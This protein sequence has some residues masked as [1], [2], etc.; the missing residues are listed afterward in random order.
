MSEPILQEP[1]VR[2]KPKKRTQGK[3]RQLPPFHVILENDD[4]HTMGFVV[5]VLQ[6][7]L[8][9]EFEKAFQLTSEAH[10]KGRAIIWTGS[11]EVAELKVEQMQT[12]HETLPDGRQLGSLGVYLEPAT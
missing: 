4:H 7:V 3:T 12:F 8:S 5:E 10:V 9:C 1:I 11:K 6:K 2:T